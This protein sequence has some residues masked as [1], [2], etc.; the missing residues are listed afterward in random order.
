MPAVNTVRIKAKETKQKAQLRGIEAGLETFRIDDGDYPRSGV[1][2]AFPSGN[3]YCGAHKLAEAMVGL[4]LMGFNPNT[5]WDADMTPS[6]P[7]INPGAY[8]TA[9]YNVRKDP[10]LELESANAFLLMSPSIP[11]IPGQQGGLGAIPTGTAPIT[12]E[13]TYVLCDVFRST[14]VNIGD[15]KVNAGTPILY[16][17]ANV[18]SKTNNLTTGTV[19][20]DF[21]DNQAIVQLEPIKTQSEA[22]N[23][24]ANVLPPGINAIPNFYEA[25]ANPQVPQPLPNVTVPYKRDSYIL[26]SAGYDG[27]YGTH[28]DITNFD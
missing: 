18:T 14:K 20:F 15:K 22:H 17:K 27:L 25:I 4:D 24:N 12:P 8:N 9:T 5:N 6:P 21:Y 26:I 1:T 11:L 16:Y 2:G 10:Y 7:L 3:A 19:V 28:D 13:N 23:Y